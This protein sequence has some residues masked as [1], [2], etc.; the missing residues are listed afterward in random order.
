MDRFTP[1]SR[2]AWRAWLANNHDT[3]DGV[4]LVFYKRGTGKENLTYDDAV[5]EALCFGWID[6]VKRSIDAERYEFRFTPRKENS[7]WSPSNKTRVERLIK[8]RK[9]TA[10][11]KRAIEAA[12]RNGRWD[13][14]DRPRLDLSM[15]DELA[16]RLSRNKRARTF[17]EGLAPSYQ[18]QFIGWI[19]SAKRDDTRQRRLDETIELL[20]RGEKLGMR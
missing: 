12:K 6:N 5:E 2:A 20:S 4:W 10:A 17:F 14:P 18:R 7:K 1:E 3:I 8:A 9:M 19:V 16:R 13:E 15:P 11:G